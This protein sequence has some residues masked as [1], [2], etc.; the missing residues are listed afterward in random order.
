M[1]QAVRNVFLSLFLLFCFIAI[2]VWTDLRLPGVGN[3]ETS[4][5]LNGISLEYKRAQEVFPKTENTEVRKEIV[6][7]AK[8]LYN[9]VLETIKID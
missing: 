4:F 9:S 5:L 3:I 1:I 8:Q 7:E 2:L 6:K